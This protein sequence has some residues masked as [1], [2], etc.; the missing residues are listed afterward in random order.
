MLK[1]KPFTKNILLWCLII[2]LILILIKTLNKKGQKEIEINQISTNNLPI[3]VLDTVANGKIAGWA[4]D[5]DLPGSSI[6]VEIKLEWVGGKTTTL[7]NTIG[8]RPDVNLAH[9]ITGLHGFD[10]E[11]TQAQKEK[12]TRVYVYAVDFNN[13]ARVQLAN[14]PRRYVPS[15]M[16]QFISSDKFIS[17]MLNDMFYLHYNYTIS[18]GPRRGN[19]QTSYRDLDI[20]PLIWFD[21]SKNKVYSNNSSILATDG[22]MPTCGVNI[23]LDLQECRLGDDV[24]STWRV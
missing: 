5:P 7:I 23:D 15:K 4:F 10:F 21:T 2:I 6:Q 24:N 9:G 3:G 20:M 13:N 22:E 17:D 8:L 1:G 19:Q 11:I 12:L 14:S 18:S 16:P